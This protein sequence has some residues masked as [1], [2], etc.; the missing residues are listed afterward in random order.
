MTSP[1][2]HVRRAFG[3]VPV[4]MS[5]RSGSDD[6]ES[7]TGVG[8]PACAASRIPNIGQEISVGLPY[9]L[10]RGKPE[11]AFAGNEV[12][13]DI[14]SGEPA[15]SGRCAGESYRWGCQGAD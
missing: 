12:V 2:V 13:I 10:L 5:D 15:L 11:F 9:G 4:I 3:I 14:D 7:V 8:V 1:C 6:D